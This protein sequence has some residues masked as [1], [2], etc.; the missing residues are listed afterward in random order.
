VCTEGEIEKKILF[1]NK[2][3]TVKLIKKLQSNKHI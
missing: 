3:E 1:V 2:M